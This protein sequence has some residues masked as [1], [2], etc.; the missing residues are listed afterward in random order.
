MNDN[1]WQ[2]PLKPVPGQRDSRVSNSKL[3][4][5]Q[6]ASSL[7]ASATTSRFSG[8]LYTDYS[9]TSQN[10]GLMSTSTDSRIETPAVGQHWRYLLLCFY[11]VF[12]GNQASG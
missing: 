6:L 9:L 8:S 7:L 5:I 11:L 10:I 3:S 12:S 2:Q 4:P 1:E